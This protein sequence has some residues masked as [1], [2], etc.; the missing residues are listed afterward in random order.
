VNVVNKFWSTFFVCRAKLLNPF[1]EVWYWYISNRDK[2]G[3]VVFLNYGYADNNKLELEKEDENSRYSIKLYD[4]AANSIR[5]EG[6]DVLEV[7]C[8][9]GGGASYIARYLEPRSVKAMDLCKKNHQF[10]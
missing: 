6:L 10:L 3:E 1:W 2:D 8:G 9:R 5:L 4:Y 7:G